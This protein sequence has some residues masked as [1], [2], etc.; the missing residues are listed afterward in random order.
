MSGAR[1][2][3]LVKLAI[4]TSTGIFSEEQTSSVSQPNFSQRNSTRKFVQVTDAQVQTTAELAVD[5]HSIREQE[6]YTN[7]SETE[8]MPEIR[9]IIHSTEFHD[10][11]MDC[12]TQTHH[13]EIERH[14]EVTQN[15]SDT[16]FSS[17]SNDLYVPPASDYNTDDCVGS[18]IEISTQD[19]T[20]QQQQQLILDA[21]QNILDQE[22]SKPKKSKGQVN[23][24]EWKR[25]KNAKLRLEGKSY[26]GFEKQESGKYKQTKIKEAK[27][28]GPRCNGHPQPTTVKGGPRQDFK[29][30]LI[31]EDDRKSIHSYFWNLSSWEAKK[32]YVTG[33]VLQARPKY[34][35]KTTDVSTS[36]KNTGFKFY[37][38]L[39]ENGNEVK[40][41]VCRNMFINTLSI[42][43]KT[44]RSW[45]SSDQ[46]SVSK[47]SEE[48]Q[49]QTSQQRSSIAKSV[50]EFLNSL[51]KVESHYCRASSSKL[52]I[53]PLWS[54]LREM[55]RFYKVECQ[56]QNK[57][58]SSWKTFYNTLK[59][60]NLDLYIPKKDQC[61]TCIQY[62]T[63][64]CDE[65][66]FR[67][68]EQKKQ[69]ARE[70]KTRDKEQSTNCPNI[71]TYTVDLQAVLL[72]PRL[73]ASANYYKTKLKVHNETFLNLSTKDAV[74]YVWHEAVGGIESDV[75]ASIFTH[76]LQKEIEKKT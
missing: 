3:L 51:P 66:T 9:A 52:Y 74:C 72:A 49:T 39:K 7:P 2:R 11:I 47:E 54:S 22:Q 70:E 20:T 30:D 18:V 61:N 46:L 44:V 23:K 14:D 75:F 55:Y 73:N 15:Q 53:E 27:C 34:R 63:G 42:G 43:E 19:V 21:D 38:T 12:T 1:S 56:T 57:I 4:S 10:V 28:L 50:E 41:R 65:E 45:I 40:K 29:C 32:V 16:D 17:G 59:T 8:P 6:R 13:E 36:R 69:S 67:K 60:M 64:T 31:N 62:K 25:L 26:V 76:F 33:C 37:F 5:Q 71:E 35:R 48:Y 68:H 24:N 58:A